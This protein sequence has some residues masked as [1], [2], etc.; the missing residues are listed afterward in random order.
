MQC[1]YLPIFSFYPLEFTQV[2]ALYKERIQFTN[3]LGHIYKGWFR[4]FLLFSNSLFPLCSSE[5]FLEKVAENG[6]PLKLDFIGGQFSFSKI[7]S[8]MH[9]MK[10]KIKKNRNLRIPPLD[11]LKLAN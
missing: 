7:S 6:P 11:A 9:Y 4:K 3:S 10:N 8:E 1:F 2:F 5:G